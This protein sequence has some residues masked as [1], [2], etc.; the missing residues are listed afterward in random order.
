MVL[1][2]S[3]C[4]VDQQVQQVVNFLTDR[5]LKSVLFLFLVRVCVCIC[6]CDCLLV[7]V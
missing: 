2:D 3:S 5:D 6:A 1:P 7:C 4:N